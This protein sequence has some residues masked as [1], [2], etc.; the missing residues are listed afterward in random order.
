MEVYSRATM[1]DDSLFKYRRDSSDEL[2]G[3]RKSNSFPNAKKVKFVKNGDKFFGGVQFTISP[4]RHRNLD[5]LLSDLTEII[6]LP[7][8]VRSI[9]TPQGGSRI[10]TIDQL[11][12]GRTYV[13]SSKHGLTK[14]DYKKV[15]SPS[16]WSAA[17]RP[18][19]QVKQ[20]DFTHKNHPL[21][22]TYTGESCGSFRSIISSTTSIKPSVIT[23]V[24]NGPAP[25]E[26]NKILVN[27]QTTPSWEYLLQSVIQLFENKT[28]PVKKLFMMSGIEVSNVLYG[29]WRIDL[30]FSK[31]L[32]S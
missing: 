17:T 26:K 21:R 14:M 24:R 18:A 13:C 32:A 10:E 25:R 4:Q 7:Y 11:E 19:K 5:A 2:P 28:N 16:N 27:Q 29:S 31:F 1:S 23:V 22:R 30:E 9:L 3:R 15:K 6:S 20:E 12:N 8:G